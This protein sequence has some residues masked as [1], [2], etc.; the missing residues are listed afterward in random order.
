MSCTKVY[1]RDSS[2]FWF[3]KW[4]FK[5]SEMIF[6]IFWGFF[7]SSKYL[8]RFRHPRQ[9]SN[10]PFP[11]SVEQANIRG[12]L[13]RRYLLFGTISTFEVAR[14]AVPSLRFRCPREIQVPA[15]W[16]LLHMMGWV[17]GC[18]SVGQLGRVLGCWGVG[19][20]GLALGRVFGGWVGCWVAEW[21]GG[22]RRGGVWC[23]E[24]LD[25]CWGVLESMF[26]CVTSIVSCSEPLESWTHNALWGCFFK[27]MVSCD[28][29]GSEV[30]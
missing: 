21:L 16:C 15:R 29:G 4:E 9:L 17:L 23:A 6:W 3:L 24:R 28:E 11:W 2:K 26:P 12:C 1:T 25:W 22:R 8:T 30:W 20:F 14:M 13:K 10:V 27:S 5:N 7:R 19:W 18:W